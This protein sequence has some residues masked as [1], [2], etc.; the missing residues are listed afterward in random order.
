MQAKKDKIMIINSWNEFI[1]PK[2]AKELLS[3]NYAN[4]RRIRQTWVDVIADMMQRGE[5]RSL[6]GQNAIIIGTD[7]ALYDGQHRL[8]AIIKSGVT[9][10]FEVKTTDTP[11]EDF[12]TYDYA[13]VRSA[14]DIVDVAN[15]KSVCA[16]ARCI[17]SIENSN[18]T[19]HSALWGRKDDHKTI[20]RTEVVKYVNA[21]QERLVDITRRAKRIYDNLRVGSTTLF[22]F[23]I[24]V[25]EYVHDDSCLQEFIDAVCG[26]DT[27]NKTVLALR[28]LL[29][30]SYTSYKK[31]SKQYVVG[32]MFCAYSHF[33]DFD[34]TTKLHR[35]QVYF[36]RYSKLVEQERDMRR[37]ANENEY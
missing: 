30:R 22:G 23:F 10:P 6:N 15:A 34:N 16:I 31:P 18:V 26:V 3:N 25:V 8:M 36:D 9:L 28:E 12:S 17:I 1:D 4:N 13:Q 14:S 11:I 21:N 27:A 19:M 7:G 29:R 5:F 24:E 33:K 37:K 35:Y 20:P 32:M 2:R